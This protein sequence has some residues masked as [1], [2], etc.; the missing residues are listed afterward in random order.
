MS[1]DLLKEWDISISEAHSKFSIGKQTDAF[2]DIKELK[3]IFSFDYISM[4]NS[5]FCF[6]GQTIGRQDYIKLFKSLKNI[7]SYT[8][9]TLNKEYRFHFHEVDWKDTS[10]SASDFYKCIYETYNGEEDITAYQFKVF[11]EARIVGFIYRGVFYLVLFDRGH[12]VYKR[13]DKKK[14]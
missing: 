10:L 12:N 13:K 1:F 2:D 7:S 11:E 8:Y 3:P 6:N 9:E 14:R 5:S 4:K